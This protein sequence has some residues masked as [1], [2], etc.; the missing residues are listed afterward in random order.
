VESGAEGVKVVLRAQ[1]NIGKE[2]VL[3]CG[4]PC[5]ADKTTGAEETA[6]G[7]AIDSEVISLEDGVDEFKRES[8]RQGHGEDGG[9]T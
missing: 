9:R 6:V 8:R 7:F 1:N 5:I 4:G 2:E 3:G